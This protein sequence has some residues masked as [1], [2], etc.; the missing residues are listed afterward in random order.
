MRSVIC[1][2]ERFDAH[3]PFVADYW[4]ARWEEEGG[5][6]LY[7]TQKAS[8]LASQLVVDPGSVNRLVLLGFPTDEQDLELFSNLEECFH[9]PREYSN[10]E[11]NF[12][13]AKARGVIFIP[14]RVDVYWGQSVA[15]F[16]LGL[17]ISALRRIPQTYKAMM[18]SHDCWKYMPPIGKPGQRGVQYG[19]DSNFTSGTLAGKR[20]RIIGA[21]NIGARYASF[22]AT[23]GA[24]VTIWDPFAPD[25]A[26]AVS[27]AKR[28]FHLSELVKDSEIFV[29]MIPLTE[30]TR[31]LVTAD[32]I[33]ALPNGSLVVQVTRAKV[34]DTEALYKRVLNDE[35]SLATDVFVEEPLDLGSPLIGRHNVV[36]TPHNGGRTK[37]AN[38]R[39]AEDQMSRFRPR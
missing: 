3:W 13:A 4:Q 7:R 22:C 25:A 39:F 34:C 11:S 38:Q 14:H 21:G 29:P 12:E 28:C 20:V 1:V 5:C 18:S 36:H 8:V 10:S 15:E 33:N 23:I 35:L 27:G 37:H 31:G 2:H 32:L 19:D 26:F 24:D 16:A 9:M 30:S 6:E 17:T